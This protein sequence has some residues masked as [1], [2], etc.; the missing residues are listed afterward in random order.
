MPILPP[1]EDTEPGRLQLM[2]Y[3]RLL[4]NLLSN[5][6]TSAQG[7][8]FETFWTRLDLSPSKPFSKRFKT[9]TGLSDT[10][11]LLDIEPM[12]RGAVDMLHVDRV[13]D[14]LEIVYRTQVGHLG[15][16]SD[17]SKGKGKHQNGDGEATGQELGEDFTALSEAEQNDL[18]AAIIASLSSPESAAQGGAVVG[19]NGDAE[20]ST[21]VCINPSVPKT[22]EGSIG[23]TDTVNANT[24]VDGGTSETRTEVH[25]SGVSEHPPPVT[26]AIPKPDEPV[27][28]ES[29]NSSDEDSDADSNNADVRQRSTVIGTKRFE[30]DSDALDAYLSSVLKLWYGKRSP[31]GVDVEL[32]RRCT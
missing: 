12:W 11:C 10:N 6:L 2:F 19:R 14:S 32:T 1:E 5:P 16:H 29:S 8:G 23:H 26:E 21:Q 17:S 25:E 7:F 27:D 3:H 31:K 4:S 9:E 30:V 20:E 15:S 28:A 13:D 22:T 24:A 18:L